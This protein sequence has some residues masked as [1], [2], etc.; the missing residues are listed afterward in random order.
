[1]TQ[2]AIRPQFSRFL[3]PFEL[4]PVAVQES[5]HG[6]DLLTFLFFCI[7]P[8]TAWIAGA[9]SAAAVPLPAIEAL[10]FGEPPLHLESADRAMRDFL[11]SSW[12]H[13][14]FASYVT[15]QFGFMFLAFTWT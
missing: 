3:I 4:D 1:M 9:V 2:L 14:R 8:Q 10:P 5:F 13:V 12:L 11:R 7:A 6:H 15:S